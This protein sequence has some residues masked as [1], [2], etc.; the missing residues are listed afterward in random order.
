MM[1]VPTGL[2]RQQLHVIFQL[3]DND[4]KGFVVFKDLL[5]VSALCEQDSL[6][7]GGMEQVLSL[8]NIKEGDKIDFD[9]FCIRV[10]TALKTNLETD[11]DDIT[12][13]KLFKNE[14]QILNSPC[15]V[16]L[17][18]VRKSRVH[19]HKRALFSPG[20]KENI[21][22]DANFPDTPSKED[23]HRAFRQ[24]QRLMSDMKEV[25]AESREEILSM[26]ERQT[27]SLNNLINEKMAQ[28]QRTTKI[29]M[30]EDRRHMEEALAAEEKV[31]RI[32]LEKES[33]EK[34][35]MRKEMRCLQEKVHHLEKT[36]EDKEYELKRLTSFNLE[37]NQRLDKVS[38]EN[39]HHRAECN[40][41][42]HTIDLLSVQ[43]NSLQDQLVSETSN[44]RQLRHDLRN[45][46]EKMEEERLAFNFDKAI[47]ASEREDMKVEI[48]RLSHELSRMSSSKKIE[49]G[50]VEKDAL[51]AAD[52]LNSNV[53]VALEVFELESDNKIA[54]ENLV[55]ENR[56]LRTKLEDF[57]IEKIGL[58]S[59]IKDIKEE[60]KELRN[61]L[62]SLKNSQS[63]E[64][65]GII[66]E[67]K[68]SVCH[69]KER[70]K[71]KDLHEE[72]LMEQQEHQKLKM[73]CS[74]EKERL[75]QEVRTKAADLE[76]LR[77][78]NRDL[79]ISLDESRNET[80][81]L[82][83]ISGILKLNDEEN[84]CFSILLNDLRD[85]MENYFLPKISRLEMMIENGRPSLDSD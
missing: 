68:E 55:D 1:A 27:V 72:L 4:Q 49:V 41:K 28:V 22:Y 79:Q 71:K 2:S 46:A 84:R 39:E 67:F 61:N 69:L 9:H 40:E 30:D 62:L 53:D 81:L 60:R 35:M 63:T 44:A 43:L 48:A 10:N 74:S 25:Q 64:T 21:Y 6:S 51:P 23:F 32:K 76:N 18:R 59:E 34:I 52:F 17:D 58:I 19:K 80:K 29:Q 16:N 42:C 78:Q 38:E 24:L 5:R 20:D 47:Y 37:L 33:A 73:I 57:Q 7:N 36:L 3:C 54:L 83:E 50:T 77:I 8:L 56:T 13:Q 82:R 66:L 45:E 85:Q 14:E 11:S 31:W 12:S 65:Q 70:V 15:R 26:I 75:Q